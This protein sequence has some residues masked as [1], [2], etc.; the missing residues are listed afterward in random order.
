MFLVVGEKKSSGKKDIQRTRIQRRR[1]AGGQRHAELRTLLARSHTPLL[2]LG[3]L[4][5]P[6]CQLGQCAFN[7]VN[8]DNQRR[9]RGRQ[10][11]ARTQR[12]P[13]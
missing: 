6:R 1:T 13:T 11:Y 10:G 2:Q 8:L 7:R 5:A 3:A 9:A 4:F 12:R